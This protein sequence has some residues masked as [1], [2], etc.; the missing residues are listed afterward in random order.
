MAFES[1]YWKRQAKGDIRTVLKKMDVNISRLKGD[2]LDKI[3]SEV[4]IKLFTIAYSLRKLM[5]TNKLPD[6]IGELE[7]SLIVF[8]RNKKGPMKPW[9]SFDEYYELNSPQ[10]AKM[11]L[12][13][14]CNSFIHAYFFQPNADSKNRLTGLFFVSDYD[15]NKQ[16]YFVSTRRLLKK[17]EKAFDQDVTFFSYTYDQKKGIY[18]I[19]TR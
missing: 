15:R 8:P 11:S 19:V 16:I 9:S 1:R 13:D 17:F 6:K 4:E 10:S 14:V 5:D 18:T 3:F 12:R 7:I 2:N